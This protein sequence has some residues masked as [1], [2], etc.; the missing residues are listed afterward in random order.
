MIKGILLLI[1][2]LIVLT[3]IVCIFARLFLKMPKI[4][5]FKDHKKTSIYSK[6]WM[7][8]LEKNDHKMIYDYVVPRKVRQ[9]RYARSHEVHFNAIIKEHYYD[10]DIAKHFYTQY[11]NFLQSEPCAKHYYKANDGTFFCMTARLGK[12]DAFS[13]IPEKEMKRILTNEPELYMQYI[14]GAEKNPDLQEYTKK[15]EEKKQ[16]EEQAQREAEEKAVAEASENNVNEKGKEKTKEKKKPLF[17]IGKKEKKE[18]REEKKEK[19]EEEKPEEKNLPEIRK[20][21][22]KKDSSDEENEASKNSYHKT[23]S[24]DSVEEKE[25]NKEEVKKTET[26]DKKTDTSSVSCE[27]P[28]TGN[29]NIEKKEKS[30]ADK[31]PV[32]RNA[33]QVMDD[34]F[35]LDDDLGAPLKD[36]KIGDTYETQNEEKRRLEREEKA[37][38]EAKAKE[39]KQQEE[40]KTDAT[41]KVEKQ[42]EKSAKA[43]PVKED[44]KLPIANAKSA[45]DTENVSET[46]EIRNVEK[47]APDTEARTAVPVQNEP[48][49]NVERD[50]TARGEEPGKKK[51]VRRKMTIGGDEERG[52]SIGFD[53]NLDKEEMLQAE[54]ENAPEIS[55]DEAALEEAEKK[56]KVKDLDFV[57]KKMP[58]SGL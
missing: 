56:E 32:D 3:V 19:K 54:E 6:D 52:T 41:A 55:I 4:F 51:R 9:A 48:V 15:Q 7:D 42:D 46:A 26:T 13:N 47:E 53:T 22:N 49:Q 20:E 31:Q 25:N 45:E 27:K 50:N 28:K 58:N 17:G 34:D 29:K 10:T 1:V 5:D 33:V 23:N 38:K 8:W 16:Q 14:A 36:S 24:T 18:D 37:R 57:M 40:K 11:T 35:D 12:K 21:E 44:S 43:T 39:K 2:A 30:K